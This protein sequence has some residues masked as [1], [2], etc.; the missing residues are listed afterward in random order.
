MCEQAAES[1]SITGLRDAALIA[2]LYCS[3]LRISEALAVVP[4]DIVTQ[5]DVTKVNVRRGKGGR[6]GW[7][8]LVQ[9]RGQL[10]HWMAVRAGM[11]LD[12]D[13]P[14]FCTISRG[15][16]KVPGGRQ[17]RSAVA[18]RLKRI[19]KAAGINKRIHCHGFRHS[20]AVGLYIKGKGQAVIMD[21]LRHAHPMT[22]A[23]YL[24]DLGCLDS[25]RELTGF[26][27]D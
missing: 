18:K 23:R 12:P 2:F 5:G 25:A 20:H 7:S 8:V 9:D 16:V 22:T 15:D 4:R 6:Q 1:E 13:A 24:R 10:A 19:G 3:G 17:D 26:S 21:Q 11:G 27:F 14:I